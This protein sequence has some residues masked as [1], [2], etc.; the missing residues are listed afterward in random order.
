MTPFG[1][2]LEI[3][4]PREPRSDVLLRRARLLGPLA[5]AVHVI[6]RPGRLSSLDAS[7]ELERAGI[8]AVWHV[9]NR[10]RTRAELEAEIERA[11]AAG[12]RAALVVR[13]EGD[14]ADRDDTPSLRASS[15]GSAPRSP[16][17]AS[18]SR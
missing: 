14:Q 10:G 3:T 5:R 7:I 1:V 9:T 2:A 13:G 18:A 17:R 12:L 8:E 15:R 11:A 6:Q 4:P 16:G